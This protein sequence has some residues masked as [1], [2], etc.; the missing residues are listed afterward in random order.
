MRSELKLEAHF[1]PQQ[2]AECL[3][4]GVA[5]G[6]RLAPVRRLELPGEEETPVQESGVPFSSSASGVN[7]RA[8]HRLRLGDVP[9]ASGD[10]EQM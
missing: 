7:A 5:G 1:L 2:M 8:A 4:P 3:L 9:G 6:F 10:G